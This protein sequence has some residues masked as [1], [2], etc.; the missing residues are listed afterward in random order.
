MGITCKQA[1]EYILKKEEG[2]LTLRQ[3]Y[4]LW[5]HLAVCTFCRLFQ[6]Q[7]KLINASFRQHGTHDHLDEEFKE[8]V[9]KAMN[10]GSG[11]EKNPG[12]L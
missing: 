5:R 1:T 2:R 8:S 10:D 12:E 9:I 4:H 7:N 6:K 11:T 3:R